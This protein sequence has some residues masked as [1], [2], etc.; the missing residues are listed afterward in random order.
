MTLWLGA[1]HGKSPPWWPQESLVATG[2][3]IVEIEYF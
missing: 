1:P 3:V 2:I